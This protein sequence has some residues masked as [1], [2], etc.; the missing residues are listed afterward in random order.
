MSKII[1]D[2]VII[3]LKRHKIS[4][5]PKAAI[6]SF[7]PENPKFKASLDLYRVP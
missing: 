4:I 7:T 2:L 1:E 6:L 3:N 5:T